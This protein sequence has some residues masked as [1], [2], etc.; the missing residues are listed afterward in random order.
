M[1]APPLAQLVDQLTA[2]HVQAEEAAK[3]AR[4][5]VSAAYSGSRQA[6]GVAAM[7]VAQEQLETAQGAARMYPR[8]SGVF[9]DAGGATTIVVVE[10][11]AFDIVVDGQ[12]H[13][14]RE[15]DVVRLPDEQAARHIGLGTAR[16]IDT[17]G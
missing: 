4:A 16:R 8:P 6:A 2:E 5:A 15:G 9:I 3:A 14:A 17:D 13:T 12:H 11:A 1:T 7:T 10:R